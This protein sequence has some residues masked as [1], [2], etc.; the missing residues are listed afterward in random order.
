[1]A[2]RRDF[3]KA[4][5]AGSTVLSR[6]VP[7]CLG[8]NERIRVGFVGIGLIGK[9]HLLDFMAEPDVE[10][11]AVC[12]VYE[13]RL[14]EGIATAGAA[15]PRA[16]KIFAGCLSAKTSTPWWFRLPTTGTH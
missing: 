11:A 13:P 16:L 14:A 8:A 2:D 7:Q 1:M 10:V 4:V 5:A 6:S 3:L 9:R 15:A 12:E